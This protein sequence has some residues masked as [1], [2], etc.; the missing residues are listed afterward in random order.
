MSSADPV[1]ELEAQDSGRP[2]VRRWS[3]RSPRTR[4]EGRAPFVVFTTQRNGS[5]WVMSVLN[6]YEGVTAQGELF[7]PRPRSPERRWDSDFAY[8]RYVESKA[9]HGRVRPRSVFHYLDAFFAQGE[10]VGFKLMYSQLRAYP[11]ILLY[12]LRRRVRVVHLVREN[13]LDVLI[14]FALKRQ[15]GKAHVLDAKDRPREPAVELP[16][17]SLLRELRWLQLKHDTARRLLRASRLPHLEVTYEE[18]VRDPRRFDDVLEFLGVS[19]DG[20]EPRSHILKT[21]L[22]GQREVVANYEEV[23]RVLAGTRFAGLLE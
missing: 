1:N 3:G 5:T 4:A 17:N 21:R 19:A 14:S 2:S 9:R 15:I 22:G 20:R 11:E 12:L 18:L 6:A 10:H 23:A 13:H 7:L 8:P 16:V